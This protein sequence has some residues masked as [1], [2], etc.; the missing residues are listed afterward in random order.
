[1]QKTTS[2][3]AIRTLYEQLITGWNDRSATGMSTPF[4]TEGEL[5]GFDGSQI[6]GRDEIFSHLDEIFSHH[7][8]PPFVYKIRSVR[9]LSEEVGIV[10]AIAGMIP[11]GKSELDP[12][13]NTHQTLV[14]A[15][16]GDKWEVT[17][18]QNTPAQFH[19][20]PDLVEQF[21]EELRQGLL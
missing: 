13:L 12:A 5:I 1:M 11:P 14:A 15:K 10:R 8:T 21:T 3:N 4:A 20:R 19:G 6:I 7:Q 9:L 18:F 16:Q 2:A 17:L